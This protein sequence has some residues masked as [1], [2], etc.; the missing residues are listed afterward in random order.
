MVEELDEALDMSLRSP[1]ARLDQMLAAHAPELRIVRSRYAS[2]APAGEVDAGKS[3]DL[4][5]VRGT[6]QLAQRFRVVEAQ[7]LVEIA[8]T[9]KAW[10]AALMSI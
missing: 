3:R 4:C 1:L 2:S 5:E 9:N 7:G 10:T 8:S 6:D